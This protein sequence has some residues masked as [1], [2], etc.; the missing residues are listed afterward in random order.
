MR[1][2]RRL[3]GPLRIDLREPLRPSER[4]ERRIDADLREISGNQLAAFLRIVD[5]RLRYVQL[6]TG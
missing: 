3:E 6:E 5:R 4:R 1:N 2:H